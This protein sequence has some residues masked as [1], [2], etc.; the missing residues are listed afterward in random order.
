[1]KPKAPRKKKAA[2]SPKTST[3]SKPAVRLELEAPQANDVYLV[4][5]FNDWHPAA[6]PMLRLD[7]G[8]W[9]KDIALPPGRYEYLFVVD[10]QWK[11]DPKAA[12]MAPNPFGGTNCVLT[13]QA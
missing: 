4:G 11:P 12:E 2:R 8:H 6:T 10:G 1:M 7:N 5:T 9:A 3:T 13:V